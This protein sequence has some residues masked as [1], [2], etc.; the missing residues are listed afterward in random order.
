MEALGAL[1]IIGI[2]ANF[3]GIISLAIQLAEILDKAVDIAKT[4]DERV[5]H[6]AVE[7]RAIAYCLTTLQTLFNADLTASGDRLFTNEDIR[8]IDLIAQQCDTI[9]RHIADSFA[10]MGRVA[11]LDAVDEHQRR[12]P[13]GSAAV[14]PSNA[15]AFKFSILG[16]LKWQVKSRDILQ[17]V[18]D[19]NQLKGSLVLILAIAESARQ[20]RRQEKETGRAA[21]KKWRWLGSLRQ[22]CKPSALRHHHHR[23][24]TPHSVK[25]KQQLCIEA[26]SAEDFSILAPRDSQSS[27]V[28]G[29][30]I[31]FSR[32][33][34][35]NVGHDFCHPPS[36]EQFKSRV[37]ITR[38]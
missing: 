36:V 14:I 33:W 5:Q 16:R 17:S 29:R 8:N 27:F 21:W 20:S 6:I 34:S 35:K 12:F 15:L 23:Q 7:L 2:I 18:A 30:M 38:S 13:S 37:L 11:V 26:A 25:E 4:A 22:R 1:G 32:P 19:L 10:R 9:F 24:P 3:A 31:G 28:V